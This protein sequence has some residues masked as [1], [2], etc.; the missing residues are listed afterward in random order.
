MTRGNQ[1]DLDRERARKRQEANAPSGKKG[2]F[3]KRRESDAEIMRRKQEEAM[4][5]KQQGGPQNEES[6]IQRKK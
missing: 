1:R 3:I 5:K 6:K 4:E 2:D